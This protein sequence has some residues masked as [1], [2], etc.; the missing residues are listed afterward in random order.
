MTRR[1]SV[2]VTGF[3]VAGA[4]TLSACGSGEPP[5]PGAAG[6]PATVETWTVTAA[7][8]TPTPPPAPSVPGATAVG[9]PSAS[10]T[11]AATPTDR[12]T[13][14]AGSPTTASAAQA[15]RQPSPGAG[16]FARPSR[17][18]VMMPPTGAGPLSGRRVVVDPGH[19][20]VYDAPIDTALV[21][22]GN[23]RRKACNTSGTANGAV[24]EHA[25][26]WDVASLLVEELR[27]RGATVWLTRPDDEGVGPCVNERAAIG[28]RAG[29]E[30]VV[31]IHADGNPSASAR[32]FHV[33]TSASMAGGAP[34]ERGSQRLA[35]L[36]RDR[37]VT[38]GMPISTYLGRRGIDV[39][40]DIAGVNL[41]EPPAV[42]LEMGNMRHPADAA[43][44]ARSSFRQSVASALADAVTSLLG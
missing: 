43:L 25:L 20:G 40:S 39:R 23:G 18:G 7:P 21:P 2:W 41:S 31:S 26:N 1:P 22:A 17:G 34:A 24:A 32:G 37:M 16:A 12:V 13:R 3:A 44:F 4:V 14:P 28:N 8:G 35:Q 15:A 38:T 33:I 30:A 29:A 9:T 27:S 10:P 6:P 11:T 19:N 5:A 36:V 42:M